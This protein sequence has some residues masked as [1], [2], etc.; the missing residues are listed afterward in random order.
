[1]LKGVQG[2]DAILDT[3]GEQQAQAVN[4]GWKEQI[5][6]GIPLPETLYS[7]PMRRAA[8]TVQITWNDILLNKGYVPYVSSPLY[9]TLAS[10]GWRLMR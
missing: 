7:S 9:A 3:L 8:Q 4:A 2:P 5:A 10:R 6:D 1:M